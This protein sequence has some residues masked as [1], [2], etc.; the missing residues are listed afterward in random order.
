MN[1]RHRA[2]VTGTTYDTNRYYLSLSESRSSSIEREDEIDD[3][4]QS[5]STDNSNLIAHTDRAL[6]EALNGVRAFLHEVYSELLDIDDNI[7]RSRLLCADNNVRLASTETESLIPL[8]YSAV[9]RCFLTID[10]FLIDEEIIETIQ[11]L[12]W[13]CQI[14][15]NELNVGGENLLAMLAHAGACRLSELVPIAELPL[16]A[17][18]YLDEHLRIETLPLVDPTMLSWL[19]LQRVKFVLGIISMSRWKFDDHELKLLLFA[20]VRIG[21]D[22]LSDY[23]LL[24]EIS[25]VLN[26]LFSCLSDERKNAI[27]VDFCKSFEFLADTIDHL[28]FALQVMTRCTALSACKLLCFERLLIRLTHQTDTEPSINYDII[29]RGQRFKAA[30]QLLCEY[31]EKAI[32]SEHHEL[33]VF[34]KILLEV[35]EYDNVIDAESEDLTIIYF[36]MLEWKRSLMERSASS[37]GILVALI[38]SIVDRIEMW[39][40]GILRISLAGE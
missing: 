2:Q 23:T 26:N 32:H 34:L 39:R 21:G 25:K 13:N 31:T 27:F 9:E 1:D 3:D 36:E 17:Q 5:I 29:S 28:Y 33:H 30:V 38:L 35:L 18:Q 14:S 22:E 7:Y 19:C 16:S 8:E 37:A 40:P 10:S 12:M 6:L 15:G 4:V 24:R 20:L 11:E